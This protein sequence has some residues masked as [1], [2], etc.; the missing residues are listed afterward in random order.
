[1]TDNT[2]DKIARFFRSKC[3]NCGEK[4]IPFFPT[5]IDDR[6]NGVHICKNCGKEWF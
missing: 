6:Q 2:L 3:T 1:M 4:A 5:Y